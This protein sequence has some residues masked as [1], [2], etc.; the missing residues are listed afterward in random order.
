[1]TNFAHKRVAEEEAVARQHR[2]APDAVIRA[3][4]MDWSVTIDA[5]YTTRQG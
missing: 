1:M 4:A 3:Q 5:T 2:E